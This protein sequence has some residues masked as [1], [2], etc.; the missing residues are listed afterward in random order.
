MPK[1]IS[2]PL[3]TH[4]AGEVTTVCTI[5]QIARRDGTV[6]YFT[7]HDA[8]IVFAGHTHMAA[9]GYTRTAIAADTVMTVNN[10]QVQGIFDSDALTAEDLRAGLFDFAEV[11]LSLVNWADLTMGELQLQRGFLGEISA[12]PSGIFSGQLNGLL[13]MLQKNIGR[14]FGPLCD[15]DLGDARCAIDLVGG[16]W[17]KNATVTAVADAQHFT[18]TVSEPRDVD[19]WFVDGVV[20]WASGLNAGRA[21]EVKGWTQ[22]TSAVQ[23]FLPMPRPVQIGDT[24]TIY[25]GCNKDVPD[26][27]DKFDNIVNHRGF[28]YVPGVDALLAA[29]PPADL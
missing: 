28:P 2:T 13:Q 27:R 18:I 17:Q 21:I 20:T 15:A 22:S 3:K 5:W 10:S 11:R 1:T 25:P 12:M 6:F 23:L 7:D 26:C 4:L 29:P 19:G 9:I 14:I 8:D 24:L 16:G